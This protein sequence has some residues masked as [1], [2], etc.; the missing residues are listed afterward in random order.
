MKVIIISGGSRGLG[1]ALTAYL[2]EHDY[3]VATFSRSRSAF[4]DTLESASGGRFYWQ[5]LDIRDH[6][7]LKNFVATV[8]SR[9]GGID[10]L[11]NNAGVTLDGLLPLTT[12][13]QIGD[14]ISLNFQSAVTLSKH[15]SRAM[16]RKNSGSIINISSVLGVRGF[17]GASVY[18]ATKAALDG[19][20]RSLA[21]EL[22]AKGIRV[23]SVA[24]GFLAT[25]MTQDMAEAKK[26]QI[27]RRTP[28]GRLGRVED[29]TG[30][31]RFLLSAEAD[32][33]T[34]QTFVVDGGLT[35]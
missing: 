29:V 11:V 10:G 14:T 3:T 7:G 15:V 16:L 30:L 5:S 12:D 25:D 18:S 33:I 1:R 22:G 34:G 27:I 26:Q 6:V 35:C 31:V 19:F 32:F 21:R 20:S 2:L 13:E 24:P 4:I 8:C 9:Y 23:N 17:K 28:L